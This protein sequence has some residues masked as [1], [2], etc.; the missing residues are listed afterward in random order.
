LGAWLAVLFA[1]I[2]FNGKFRL[3]SCR[4]LRRASR[5]RALGTVYALSATGMM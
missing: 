1:P 4:D 3:R 5:R 2:G